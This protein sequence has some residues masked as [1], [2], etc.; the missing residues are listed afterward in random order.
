MVVDKNDLSWI[1]STLFGNYTGVVEDLVDGIS[2]PESYDQ[3]EEYSMHQ[4]EQ[5]LK[6]AKK[7]DE[8]KNNIK[9]KYDNETESHLDNLFNYWQ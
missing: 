8:W 3:V 2:G 6:N 4:I 9:N 5:A 1:Q 7:W